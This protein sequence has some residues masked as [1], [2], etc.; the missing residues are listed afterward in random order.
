MGLGRFQFGGLERFRQRELGGQQLRWFGQ[1]KLGFGRL[2]QRVLGQRR[3][4]RG[5][6]R[7]RQLGFRWRRLGQRLLGLVRI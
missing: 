5:R 3:L 6:L 2:G 1:R 7:Q 4:G